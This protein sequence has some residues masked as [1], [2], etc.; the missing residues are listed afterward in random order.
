M[1]THLPPRC[2]AAPAKRPDSPRVWRAVLRHRYEGEPAELTGG[3]FS[4]PKNYDYKAH[5]GGELYRVKI[6]IQ[7]KPEFLTDFKDLKL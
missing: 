1:Q 7:G 2:P 4:E 6:D 3:A 5:R